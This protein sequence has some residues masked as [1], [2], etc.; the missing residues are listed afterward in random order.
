MKNKKLVFCLIPALVFS[1]NLLATSLIE[2]KREEGQDTMYVD[3]YKMLIT[4]ID[5]DVRMIMDLQKKKAY[6]V[7]PKNKS[8]MDMSEVTW[9]ALKEAGNK[10]APPKVDARL[11][12][13]GP[14][15]EIAGY[16][17]THYVIY[18]DGKKC[19][20]KW[21]SE[22]ALK[23]SGFGTIWGDYGDFLVSA[24]V[25]AGDHPCELA[26]Y[27]VFR[28][29]KFGLAL[30]ETDHNCETSEVLRIERNAN[31]DR[32]LFEIPADYKVVKLPTSP[33]SGSVPQGNL[34][35]DGTWSWGRWDGVDCADRDPMYGMDEDYM[36]EEYAD[37]E[38]A[39]E[40]YVEDEP[41]GS[42]F[43]IEDI[44]KEVADE[45]VEGLEEKVKSKFKG[46]MKKIKKKDKN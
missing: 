37:E 18:V 1:T 19:A 12:K 38:Y 8:A 7:N 46:F 29:D 2:T 41:A 44:T 5:E 15:P 34:Q 20:E 39:D 32:S 23:D 42:D 36:D 26:E 40:E 3:G 31:V 43:S 14:G 45:E 35:E 24:S 10:K 17:T 30:K 33:Y 9:K 11:E 4:G 6:M 21:T 25:S 13:A 16:A 27:Q 22:K 28:D